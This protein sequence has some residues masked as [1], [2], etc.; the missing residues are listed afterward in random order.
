MNNIRLSISA[1]AAL[2]AAG[3]SFALP[4]IAATP[5]G[6]AAATA[7]AEQPA[8]AA[9]AAPEDQ[10]EDD[11]Y[12]EDEIIVT[13]PRLAGQLATDIRAEAELDE[14]AVASYGASSIEE[15]LDALEPQ[16]RS[17][18]GRGG[19]PV[20]LVNGRRISG[21]GAVRN[22]PPEAI[23]KVEIFPEEVALEYGY[24]ATERVVNFVLKPDFRQISVEAE[25]GI[26]TQGGQFKNELEPAFMA[27]GDNGRLNLNASW[28]HQTMLRESERDL[29]YDDPILAAGAPAARVGESE[30][31]KRSLSSS[32]V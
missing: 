30:T 10:E 3:A 20:I 13:A 4:V 5:I 9:P 29:V 15:L 24:A 23:A 8:E 11:E 31:R 17:G 1:R 18:R 19:R 12:S 2:L 27:I 14:A 16:T 6:P 25:A 7:V 26:P 21:F 22:I 32:L 28:E